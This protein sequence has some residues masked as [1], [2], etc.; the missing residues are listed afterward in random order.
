MKRS[1]YE[2]LGVGA[3][4]S[5][6]E[7]KAAYRKIAKSVHPDAGGGR[8]QFQTVSHAFEVLSDPKKRAEYDRSGK[9]EFDPEST[10]YQPA[11]EILDSLV[12]S[13]VNALDVRADP[14]AEIRGC[15][16]R[17]IGTDR[18][19]RAMLCD[20]EAKLAKLLSRVK[21]GKSS[22]GALKHIFNQKLLL[23]RERIEMVTEHIIVLEHALELLDGYSFEPDEEPARLQSLFIKY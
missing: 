6:A 16:K 9:D 14:I 2:I 8:D 22:H 18:E 3:D 15:I 13:M 21:P 10:K 19:A 23:L 20:K 12:S 1:L 7:I 11:I 5:P 4:A 17:G